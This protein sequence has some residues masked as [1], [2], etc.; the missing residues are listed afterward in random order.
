MGISQRLHRRDRTRSEQSLKQT[1]LFPIGMEKVQMSLYLPQEGYS[2]PSVAVDL[3]LCSLV[4]A[5]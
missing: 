1:I 5:L 4:S 3:R 2:Q